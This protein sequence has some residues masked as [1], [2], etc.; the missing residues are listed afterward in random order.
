MGIPKHLNYIEGIKLAASEVFLS[1]NPLEALIEAFDKFQPLQRGE[2]ESIKINQNEP[3]D[4][5]T[6][7]MFPYGIH[8][9]SL[10]GFELISHE[11]IY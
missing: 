4:S 7:F 10:P 8:S 6:G 2:G 11:P 5:P 9:T 1:D 3:K